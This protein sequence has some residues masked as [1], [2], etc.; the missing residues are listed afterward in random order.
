M[1]SWIK[2]K[3][4]PDQLARRMES[5]KII[6]KKG[7]ASFTGFKYREHITLLCSMLQFKDEIPDLEKR[8]IIV[9]GCFNAGSK[10][11]INPKRL[12]TEIGKLE[13]IY[14]KLPTKKYYLVTTISISQKIK[15]KRYNIGKCTVVF[16]SNLPKIFVS[17]RER[18][19]KH[20]QNRFYSPLPNEYIFVRVALLAKC[21]ADAAD[22]AI[23]SLDLL[24]G[25]WNLFFNIGSQFRE[26]LAGKP[27]PVNKFILG[28]VHTIHEYSGKTSE[29]Y[30]YD[31]HYRGAI[32]VQDTLGRNIIKMYKFT[33]VIRNYLRKSKYPDKLKMAILR[34]SHALDIPEWHDAFL[35]LWTVL[36]LLTN[37]T[38]DRYSVTV[39]RISFLFPDREYHRQTLLQLQYARNRKV[40]S[41]LEHRDTEAFMYQAKRYVEILLMFHLSNSFGFDNLE[42]VAQF[43]DLPNNKKEIMSKIKMMQYAK[44]FLGFEK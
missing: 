23:D 38:G 13:E 27:F 31:P 30:W 3:Y 9:K 7:Q 44:K 24:R 10:G 11:N 29:T 41:E 15:I 34:Y 21:E 1:V 35:K 25:I 14:L 40:H 22:K 36:E 20:A 6:N 39:R 2:D 33:N 12:I 26:T 43:M 17:E 18:I 16:K 42:H 32:K 28:P 4:D 8:R 5:I 19:I 37:T